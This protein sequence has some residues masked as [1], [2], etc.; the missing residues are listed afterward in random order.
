MKILVLEDDEIINKVY[1]EHYEEQ[2]HEV[3]SALTAEDAIRI[4]KE[5]QPD[6]CFVDVNLN[7]SQMDGVEAIE[8]MQAIK[9]GCYYALITCRGNKETIDRAK[10]LGVEDFY[11]KPILGFEKLTEILQSAISKAGVLKNG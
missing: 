8:Q 6:I 9:S 3:F 4:Y 7:G 2:G 1:S 5:N 10:A 11:F